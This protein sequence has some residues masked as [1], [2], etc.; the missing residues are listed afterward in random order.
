MTN[1]EK[2]HKSLHLKSIHRSQKN[3]W[4]ANFSG[5]LLNTWLQYWVKAEQE[6]MSNDQNPCGV[7]YRVRWKEEENKWN[8]IGTK[9]CQG[10]WNMKGMIRSLGT[11][12]EC[13]LEKW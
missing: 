4:F 9:E 3:K 10:Q 8:N 7:N 13:L 11:I 1:G 2:L 6:N 12:Q 5:Q